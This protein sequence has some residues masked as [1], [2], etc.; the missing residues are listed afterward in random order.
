MISESGIILRIGSIDPKLTLLKGLT[1]SKIK[2]GEQVRAEEKVTLK[3]TLSMVAPMNKGDLFFKKIQV[4]DRYIEAYVFDTLIVRGTPD[5]MKEVIDNGDL[6]KVINKLY[7]SK[8]KRG[9]INLGDHNYISFS[10]AF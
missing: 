3:E 4:K 8:I 1:L 7:K 10:P 6:Q 9:T 2:V 5:R